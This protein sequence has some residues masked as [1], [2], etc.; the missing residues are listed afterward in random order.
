M[1]TLLT[2]EKTPKLGKRALSLLKNEEDRKRPETLE[3]FI[4]EGAVEEESGD[5]WLGSDLAKAL[6][7]YQK[8]FS[9]YKSAID[10]NQENSHDAYYNALRLLYLVYSQYTKVDSI[11]YSKLINIGEVLTGDQNSVVQDISS[12]VAAHEAAIAASPQ[13]SADLLYNTVMVYTDFIEECKEVQQ[14]SHCGERAHVLLGE[15]LERQKAQAQAQ[16]QA[17][18]Q[19]QGLA[20]T[21]EKVTPGDVL[22]TVVAG[23]K[24]TQAILEQDRTLRLFLQPITEIEQ[25]GQSVLN[26]VSPQ[27]R[28]EFLVTRAY[29]DGLSRDSLAELYDVWDGDL[30]ATAEKYMLAADSI[31]TFLTQND[32]NAGPGTDPD[33]YWTALTKMNNYFKAAQDI[34]NAEYQRRKVSAATESGLGSLISQ[35]SKVYIARADI[36]LQRGQLETEQART[37][38]EL[39]LRN[40]KAFLKNAMNLAKTSGG[41]RE[42]VVEKLEREKRRIEAVSRLCVLEN[43]TDPAELDSIMGSGTWGTEWEE[44]RGLWYFPI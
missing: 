16:A 10:L 1:W 3:D 21:E 43:K 19:G 14:I 34:L 35:L 33:T 44:Y 18:T 15:L 27:E 11:E 38:A 12:I 36:D 40:A 29:V 8:A 9:N 5:R 24:L 32:I 22:D 20:E 41:I 17:Q 42:T 31:E 7:F 6:R 28:E 4:E 39:L 23:F 13:P 30:P 25:V 2:I 37:N 26:E